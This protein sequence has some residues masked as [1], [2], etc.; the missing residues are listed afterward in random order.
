MEG[1]RKGPV[2]RAPDPVVLVCVT[3]PA[4]GHVYQTRFCGAPVH[5]R[6]QSLTHFLVPFL[7]PKGGR[8]S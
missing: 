6:D 5:R 1:L 7:S 2:H 8:L 3:L 4:R